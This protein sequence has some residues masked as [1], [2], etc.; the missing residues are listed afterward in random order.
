MKNFSFFFIIF[1]LRPETF[2][3]VPT[4]LNDAKN[5]ARSECSI[6]VVGNKKDLKDSRVIKYND[7]AKFCQEN[8]KK[9]II[10]NII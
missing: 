9:K 7:G 6:C 1:I 2:Q 5:S 3:H 10:L 8:S 4:W